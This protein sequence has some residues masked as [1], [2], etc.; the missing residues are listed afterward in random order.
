M[1][2]FNVFPYDSNIDFMRLRM[3]SLV[4]AALIMFVGV[5]AMFTKGFNFALD[6]TGGVGIELAYDKPVDVD[7]V[8]KRLEAAGYESAQ[9]QTFGTGKELLVRL[10]DDSKTNAGE[11]PTASIAESVRVAASEPGNPAKKLRSAEISPQ[12]GRELAENGLYAVLFVVIGFLAYISFRFEWKFAVAAIVTTLHDVLVVAG[13]FALSG[14]EFDLT[15]LA[16]VLSVMGYSI[17]DTIVVF[18]RVRE[19]FR[20]MRVSPGEVLNKSIN[21]TLSRTVITSFVAF[22]TVL[23]LYLYGGGSLRGMAESQMLGIIIGTLSSIFVACPLLLWLGVNKQDLMP[24]A[25][26]EAALARRP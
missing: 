9:V 25:R 15:V 14:H 10:R 16:G 21:Q 3:I 11:D 7:G 2:P 19:N 6:F 17:N 22:L 5:G 26:D 13:W 23:A 4:V 12:V 8:R 1:K 24:K 18:D 20:G